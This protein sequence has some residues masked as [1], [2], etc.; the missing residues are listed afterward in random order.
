M[1]VN[2]NE[3]NKTLY[4]PLY[5]KAKVSKKGIILEDRIAEEIWSKNHFELKGKAKSKWLAYFM[6]M[7]SKVFDIWAAE[8]IAVNSNT[9]VLH[10]GCGLDSRYQRLNA[11]VAHW[12]DIDFPDVIAERKQYFT[13]NEH[14]TML[15]G[16]A[17]LP[18]EWLG[19]LAESE[20]AII[21]LEG[22]SMYLELPKLKELLFE[23]SKKY[24]DTC[25]LM[26]IYTSFAAKATKYKNPINEV[27]V[28][29]VY[30]ID[31]PLIPIKDSNINFINERTMT[32]KNLVDELKGFD[33]WF[34]NV[35]FVGKATRKIYRLLE[36]SSKQ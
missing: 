22:I 28:T 11:N 24:N 14:Y 29:T 9:V 3:V 36:Y 6:A 4:I 31:D 17:S 1:G 10:I 5:G 13:E 23:I 27:G 26:D 8:Q 25:I 19:S 2:M 34:F 33:H 32:P 20:K 30:G 35:M 12:Y 21:I 16:D 15:C 18:Q 7:R